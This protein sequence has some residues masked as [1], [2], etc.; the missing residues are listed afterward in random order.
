M[1]LSIERSRRV[2][3]LTKIFVERGW[4]KL[5]QYIARSTTHFS[6]MKAFVVHTMRNRF[7]RRTKELVFC[8]FL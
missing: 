7:I 3:R 8:I 1:V 4:E 5:Q 2:Q 6:K